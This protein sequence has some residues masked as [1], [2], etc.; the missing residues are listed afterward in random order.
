MNQHNIS[1][2][3]FLTKCASVEDATALG[4]D[5]YEFLIA[6]GAV[7]KSAVDIALAGRVV[8]F[9]GSI[10]IVFVNGVYMAGV[11]QA[12]SQESAEKLAIM[13]NEKL[14]AAR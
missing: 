12:D 10:E 14:S 7:K 9:Y 6:N 2:R 13:L 11:H 5:Y 8:D 3:A 1:R 4:Q